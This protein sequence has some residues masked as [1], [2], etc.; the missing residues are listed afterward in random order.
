[1]KQLLYLVF[2]NRRL[3]A[4]NRLFL[5]YAPVAQLDRAEDF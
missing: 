2:C 1:M 5:R 3:R 4:T